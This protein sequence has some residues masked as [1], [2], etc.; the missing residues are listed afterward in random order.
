MEG[1]ALGSGGLLLGCIVLFVVLMLFNTPKSPELDKHVPG[2]HTGTS[3]IALLF[4]A[5]GLFVCLFGFAFVSTGGDMQRT[6]NYMKL[7]GQAVT[8]PNYVAPKPWFTVDRQ[9]AFK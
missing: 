7:M 1:A 8:D 2:G 9:G 4:V 5:V 6:E 3:G